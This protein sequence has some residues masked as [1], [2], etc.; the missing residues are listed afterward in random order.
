MVSQRRILMGMD[1]SWRLH[2]LAREGQAEAVD[3]GV[4]H[5]FEVA[6]G[7][8]APFEGLGNDLEVVVHGLL[9]GLPSFRKIW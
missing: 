8:D 7:H 2:E 6:A 3:V 4:G 5:V 1:A 9:A